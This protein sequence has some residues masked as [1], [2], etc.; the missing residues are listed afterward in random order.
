MIHSDEDEQGEAEEEDEEENEDEEDEED[1][2]EEDG[3]TGGEAVGRMVEFHET[4]ADFQ[5]AEE[6]D[7]EAVDASAGRVGPQRS[8]RGWTP[9]GTRTRMASPPPPLPPPRG[10]QDTAVAGGPVAANN[11][12]SNMS[13]AEA[14]AASQYATQE[15]VRAVGG[16]LLAPIAKFNI[17]R[18]RTRCIITFDPPVTAKFVLLKMWNPPPTSSADNIDIR[19]VIARGFCGPRW[20]PAVEMC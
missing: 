16:Q 10:W 1:E 13:L 12:T 4:I 11:P 8:V 5:G 18:G 17:E 7:H 14:V 6:S 9:G 19:Q 15:A 2:D 3:D 20:V